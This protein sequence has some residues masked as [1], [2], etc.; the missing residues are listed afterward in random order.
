[1]P[2]TK[3]IHFTLIELL[4]VMAIIAILAAMLLPALNAAR[5]KAKASY[6]ISNL[7]QLGLGNAFYMEDY[8]GR[9]T[10]TKVGTGTINSWAKCYY[11]YE[12]VKVHKV[13][14]CPSLT[15][16]VAA[17]TATNALGYGINLHNI[18]SSG[19]EDPRPTNWDYI[20]LKQS[21]VKLPSRTIFFG[22]TRNLAS[23]DGE[24]FYR[25]NSE[26][27]TSGGNAY[28][29]HNSVMNIGW[30]DG[31]ASGVKCREAKNPYNELGRCSGPAHIGDG[32]YWDKSNS[33]KETL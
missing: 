2:K 19:T 7:K 29:R 9:Y 16:S 11:E 5:E 30:A 22:D 18:A 3:G 25:M 33:R 8:D 26:N 14:Y 6:C 1:M 31:S 21:Q 24:G 32:N 20:S 4:V 12:Y 28:A 23:G 17:V 27:G 10:P 15:R 13:F